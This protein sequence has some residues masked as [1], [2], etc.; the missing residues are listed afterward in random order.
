M[1]ARKFAPNCV[2][3]VELFV[4]SVSTITVPVNRGI[5]GTRKNAEGSTRV[6]TYVQTSVISSKQEVKAHA[7]VIPLITTGQ[8]AILRM[9]GG[10]GEGG[11]IKALSRL[12]N[13]VTLTQI[14]TIRA[15][16]GK[17]VPLIVRICMRRSEKQSQIKWNVLT[18]QSQLK[19]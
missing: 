17:H 10:G 4:C 13:F 7:C 16:W 2:I 5:R 19:S 18:I 3:P 15:S 8:E 9:G 1:Q 12:I 14:G 11:S 6:R